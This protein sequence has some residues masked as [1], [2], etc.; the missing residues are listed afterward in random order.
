MTA[1][2]SSIHSLIF[3]YHMDISIQTLVSA[4]LA[5]FIS[6]MGVTPKFKKFG[7]SVREN[8]ALQNIQVCISRFTILIHY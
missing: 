6:V 1:V 2:I 7:G 5:L 3:S 8:Q 4:L